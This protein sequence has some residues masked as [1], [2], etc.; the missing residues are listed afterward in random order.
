[1]MTVSP[2]SRKWT[3]KKM[4][5]GLFNYCFPTDYRLQMQEKM[6]RCRQRDHAVHEYVHE[7]ETLFLLVGQ[8]SRHKKRDK[9]RLW[10]G[11]NSEL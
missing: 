5:I 2:A 4:F 11:L 3:L 8:V 7:L 6:N 9:L 10:A 1:M